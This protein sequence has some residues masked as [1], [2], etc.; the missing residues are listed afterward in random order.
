MLTPDTLKK[1]T[2]AHGHKTTNLIIN[3]DHD[4]WILDD[5]SK[6]LVDVGA[7]ES[8][9]QSAGAGPEVAV[10]RRGFM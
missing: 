4:E 10:D 8:C 2:V 6:V 3:L 9:C 7:G 1:Y 5:L